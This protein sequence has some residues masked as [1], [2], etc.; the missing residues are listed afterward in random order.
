MVQT[1]RA[2]S[3]GSEEAVGKAVMEQFVEGTN[4]L[5]I[6]AA[7]TPGLSF[8]SGDALGLD[9]WSSSLYMRGFF[10]DRLGMTLDGVPLND[11]SYNTI[12]GLNVSQAI[13][14]D[15]IGFMSVSQG[16]GAVDVPSNTNL[17]G[18]IRFVSD[19]PADK[20][21]G[22]LSQVFGSN[23]SFRTYGRF[24]TGAMN[25][26]GTKMYLAYARSDTQKWKGYGNQLGQ[27][28]EAK[29][30]QPVN[31]ASKVSAFMN[32]SNNSQ[33]GYA[34][35]SLEILNK[36]GWRTEYFYPD[37]ATAYH[38]AQGT[39]LPP[40]YYKITG[41]E[42]WSVSLYDGGQHQVSYLGALNL[43]FEMTDHLRWQT[44]FYGNSEVLYTTYGDPW[45]PS[46]TGAPFS[47]QVWES[48]EVRYG[49]TSAV[50]YDIARNS[51]NTGI[52]LENNNQESGQYFFNEPLLGQGAPL[53]T[54]GPYNTYG[55]AFLT[56]YDFKWT[57]NTFQYFLADTYHVLKNLDIHA[58]FRSMIVSTSGGANYNNT[59]YTGEAALANGSMT[60]ASAFLPNV[61][62]NWR[63]L[64]GHE[65]YFDVAEN[66]RGYTVAPWGSGSLWGVQNQDAFKTLQHSV[67]PE[68]DWV[69]LVGY[70]YTSPVVTASLDGYHADVRHRLQQAT[71]GTLNFPITTMVDTGSISMYGM[72]AGLTFRPFRGLSI[73]N[74][75]SYNH[76]TYG[77]DLVEPDAVY[78]M[79]GKKVVN[80]PQVMYKASLSYA[81]RG[82][83]A[84]IDANY[85]SKRYF[86]YVNDTSVPAYWLVTLGAKYHFGDYGPLKNLSLGFNVYNLLNTKYISMM[87][88]NGNPLSGDYQ[89]LE[90]GAVR[91]FFGTVSAS[92]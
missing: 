69:Y 51:L 27:Q 6:L 15:D 23:S 33:W 90:R 39:Y 41:Q 31:N 4:P 58:G 36:L 26:T 92:F 13:I 21:G 64:P 14:T 72:D 28:A 20:M 62:A 29:L 32:W 37:Y 91:Q 88:E 65:L 34:D 3:R 17:G 30:V 80:F 9:A 12:S 1:S 50:R 68:K 85:Y 60:A 49:M 87:G 77:R 71:E 89:S 24:D 74:S 54:I 63:F 79:K 22:K 48:R 59:D 75:V 53:K 78:A 19:D 42:P 52:W 7:R 45:Q 8:S 35:Q 56:S 86:S 55:P 2:V 10:W 18:A 25:R 44:N 47:E 40:G 70:R 81:W 46:A 43:D 76:S 5:K 67:K 83:E 11:Q 84:H 38:V 57:T 73:Y 82:A 16:G 61:S 66:M